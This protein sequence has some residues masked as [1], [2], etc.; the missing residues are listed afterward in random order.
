MGI[1]LLHALQ[2]PLLLV[3]GLGL[4]GC[5]TLDH[6]KAST[7]SNYTCSF[8][9]IKELCFAFAA[10]KPP[11]LG[12]HQVHSA[13]GRCH[14]NTSTA[15]GNS[16]TTKGTISRYSDM[17]TGCFPC[18]LLF[19]VVLFQPSLLLLA[20]FLPPQRRHRLSPKAKDSRPQMPPHVMP[21]CYFP[22]TKHQIDTR[23]TM[24]CP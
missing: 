9:E 2:L 16:D 10:A 15:N 6:A 17:G 1:K 18:F 22:P 23:I 13:T 14:M 11:S 4:L 5:C 7:T 12:S 3:K 24:H 20:L 21:S 8:E 19:F